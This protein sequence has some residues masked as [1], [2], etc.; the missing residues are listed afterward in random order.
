MLAGI[1]NNDTPIDYDALS[2]CVIAQIH[3]GHDHSTNPCVLCRD[4][5]IHRFK[6]CP[7]LQDDNFK[8][9][10]ILFYHQDDLLKKT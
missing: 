9:S 2:D 7:L 1:D 8:T 10:F 5:K 3:T 4:G 6:D